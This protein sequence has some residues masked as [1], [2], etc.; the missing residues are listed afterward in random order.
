MCQKKDSWEREERE[1]GLKKE[2]KT[3]GGG[4]MSR[5]LHPKPTVNAWGECPWKYEALKGRKESSGSDW[6]VLL[7][8]DP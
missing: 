7:L 8:Q 4:K 3:E 6:S 2:E 1:K 5:F